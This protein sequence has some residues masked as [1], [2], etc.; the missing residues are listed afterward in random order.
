MIAKRLRRYTIAAGDSLTL[1]DFFERR[2]GDT[3]GVLRTA[4]SVITVFFVIFYVSSGLVAG[5]KLLGTVFGLD[6]NFGVLVTHVAVASYTFIGGFSRSLQDRRLSGHPHGGRSHNSSNDVDPRHKRSV[7][8]RIG[9]PGIHESVHRRQQRPHRRCGAGLGPRMG[10]RR[11]RRSARAP[12]VHGYR[13]RRLHSQEQKRL[14]SVDLPYVTAFAILLG[15]VAGP[16]L[17]EMGLLGGTAD[18][19]RI[20]LVTSEVFFYPILTGLLLTALIAAVMSTADSQLLLASAVASDDMPFIRRLAR[21]VSAGARVWLG[22]ILLL[23]I[24]V[25]AAALSIYHQ[26]SVLNLVSYAWGG[27]GAAFGPLTIMALYWRRF[28]FWG[29]L[30]AMV[31]GTAAASVWGTLAGGPWGIWDIDPATPGF[32]IG[33]PAAILATLLTPRPSREVVALFD[34]VNPNPSAGPDGTVAPP[35]HAAHATRR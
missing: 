30:T 32:A 7:R 34:K 35:T 14:S 9:D 31:V 23:I 10:A 33:A 19:E 13:Q 18:P 25:A 24:G 20:Y 15:L 22:R 16:A 17:A 2:F 8:S 6:E 27:M 1:P 12:K 5:A 4:A 26:D 21:A 29:A 28:N 11:V 3:T